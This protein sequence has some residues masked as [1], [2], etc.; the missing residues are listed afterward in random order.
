MM[1]MMMMVIKSQ[2]KIETAARDIALKFSGVK[3]LAKQ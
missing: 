3:T 1:M 2:K